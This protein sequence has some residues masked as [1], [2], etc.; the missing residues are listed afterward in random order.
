MI[1]VDV[2]GDE[3]GSCLLEILLEINIM[4]FEETS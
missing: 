3:V 2:G 1:F 4:N